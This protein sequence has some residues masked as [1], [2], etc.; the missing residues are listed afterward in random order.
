MMPLPRL[1]AVADASFG[2]PVELAKS[3]F[4]G[5]IRFLQVRNKRGSSHDLLNQVESILRFAP[6]DARVIVNDRV[7]IALISE[8][9]GVHLGQ[10]DLS[11]TAARQILGPEKIIGFSTHNMEQALTADSMPVDYIAVGPIFSTS[12]KENPD[13]VVGQEE[14]EKIRNKIFKPIVAIGGITYENGSGVWAT[15]VEA[16]AVIRDLLN[17]ENIVSRTRQWIELWATVSLRERSPRSGR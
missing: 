3:L 11:P 5:G 6:A 16:V 2:N 12:T 15:G 1:Y 13:P 14:L 9:A 7:D 17:S 10:S 4:E 8:V